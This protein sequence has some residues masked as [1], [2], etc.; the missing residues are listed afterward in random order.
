M[1]TRAHVVV[2]IVTLVTVV[3]ILR[4]VNAR[5]MR[6]KYGLL[7]LVIAVLML[8]IA[9]FPGLLDEISRAIGVHYP[10]TTFLLF[11]IGF[12]FLVVVH[13]SWELSRTETR[14][15]RLAEELALLRASVER[16]EDAQRA[17]A[18]GSGVRRPSAPAGGDA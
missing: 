9:A 11:A 12:L 2:L 6:S 5:R 18:G 3:F 4:S 17:V 15:R 1:S 13:Y 10:P 8:C 16:V 14:L 7:W